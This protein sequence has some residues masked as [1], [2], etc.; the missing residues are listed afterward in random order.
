M[1]TNYPTSLDTTTELPEPRA[2][3]DLNEAGYEHDTL[4]VNVN[5]AVR[6]LE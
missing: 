3:T 6:E 2:T 1:A 4:H 5:Q